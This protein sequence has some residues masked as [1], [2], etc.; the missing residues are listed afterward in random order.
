M[1][2]FCLSVSSFSLYIQQIRQ[3]GCCGDHT[4]EV[5]STP[6]PQQ[7]VLPT[8]SCRVLEA[9]SSCGKHR[10]GKKW[11]EDR[12]GVVERENKRNQGL[13]LSRATS[14]FLVYKG[15]FCAGKIRDESPAW[16][17]AIKS[18]LCFSREALYSTHA[19]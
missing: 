6:A 2:S 7:G 16:V 13:Y 4:E 17:L 1:D 5:S 14:L 8:W 18:L 11:E 9:I 15:P 3:A 12:E 19:S 10:R